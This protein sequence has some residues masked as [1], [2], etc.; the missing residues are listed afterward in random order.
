VRARV[1]SDAGYLIGLLDRAIEHTA[2][3]EREPLA[4]LGQ[5]DVEEPQDLLDV[6]H[7]N[8][9][10]AV[11]IGGWQVERIDAVRR[12][13][14]N[15]QKLAAHGFAQGAVLV[16]AVDDDDVGGVGQKQIATRQ[17]LRKEGLTAA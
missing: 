17:D 4:R 8:R 9:S 2:F 15:A 11:R 6:V 16:L 14:S 7:Q 3:D 13:R 10:F 1:L 12:R 5:Q